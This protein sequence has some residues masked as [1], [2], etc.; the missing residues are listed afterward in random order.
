M[1]K[2]ALPGSRGLNLTSKPNG[3]PSYLKQR[4][5]R[6]DESLFRRRLVFGLSLGWLMTLIGGANLLFMAHSKG[7]LWAPISF[8]GVLLL[9]LAVV[10]PGALASVEDFFRRLTH[11]IGS[12]IFKLVLVLVYFLIVTPAGMF[13]RRTS[14]EHFRSWQNGKGSGLETTWDERA[15]ARTT[16]GSRRPLLYR[17]LSEFFSRANAAMLPAVLLLVLGGLL[18]FFL[19]TSAFAPF[20]YTLF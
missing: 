8:A 7:W 13:M 12:A 6:L 5:I 4:R 18:M 3:K 19:E 20:I 1:N 11:P 15:P 2:S 16:V 10:K 9:F 14:T 17:V